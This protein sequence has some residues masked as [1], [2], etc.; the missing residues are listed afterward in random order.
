MSDFEHDPFC[1]ELEMRDE[2]GPF[3]VHM[4]PSVFDVLADIVEKTGTVN[5]PLDPWVE[6][7]LPVY[8]EREDSITRYAFRMPEET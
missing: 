7:G 6:G 1:M 3:R 8:I 4:P 5:L 2:L